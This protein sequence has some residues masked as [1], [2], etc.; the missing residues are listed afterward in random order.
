MRRALALTAALLATGCLGRPADNPNAIVVAIQTGPNNLD[1]RFA[2]DDA[3]QKIDD[4]IFDPLLDFDDQMRIVPRLAERFDHPDPM[5]YVAALPRGVLF[6]DGHELT[7]ADVL[8]TFQNLIDPASTSPRRGGYQELA[9]VAARD[10]YTVVFTLS[11]PFA[12]FPVDLVAMPILPAGAPPDFRDRPIGTGPYRF[13]TYAVDDRVVLA[14]FDRYFKGAPRNAGLLLKIVPDDV[15]RGL[16]LRKGTVDLVLND[17]GPDI[18]YPL[19]SDPRLQHEE[20]QGLDYQY[21]GLNLRD[22][23]LQDVRVRRALAYAIDRRAI[24]DYL[25]RGLAVQA[26]GLLPP[27]SWAFA[28]DAFSFPYDPDR[29]RRLLDDAGFSDPDGDGPAP[30]FH[31][32]MKIANTQEFQTL[33]AAAI[34]QNLRAIGVD[35]EIRTYEFATMFADVIG[36]NFQMYTLQWTG[37]ALADPD[38]LRRVFHSRQ[39]PPT[40]FNRGHFSDREV[41]ALLDEAAASTDDHLRLALFRQ[42]QREVALQVPYISLWNKTNFVVGQRSLSGLHVSSRADLLFLK[43]VVRG[44]PATN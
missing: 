36:G 38:I 6:H 19:F 3:S 42:V 18:A 40:G 37:G 17:L 20:T 13:V 16:E 7:S 9:A 25:R 28:A 44:G 15:M 24:V 4:L 32:T 43:D 29:A 1:P 41:D 5:T 33:Q 10:R 11:H 30:R 2:L 12:S 27:A 14:P 34:Q 39:T 23:I 21:V 35:L 22:P 26:V 8:F 31:L